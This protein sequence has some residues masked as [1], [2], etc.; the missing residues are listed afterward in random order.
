MWF[1]AS[2]LYQ[3]GEKKHQHC[4]RYGLRWNLKLLPFIKFNTPANTLAKRCL[5]FNMLLQPDLV[6]FCS[7]YGRLLGLYLFTVY[8]PSQARTKVGERPNKNLVANTRTHSQGENKGTLQT[9]HGNLTSR[10]PQSSNDFKRIQIISKNMQ[11]YTY[12]SSY[13]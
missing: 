11:T 7:P 10:K 9:V 4:P 2:F 5:C 13:R 1:A 8:P 6:G 12:R 3:T